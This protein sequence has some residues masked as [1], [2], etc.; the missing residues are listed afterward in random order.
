[1][2]PPS[3]SKPE[4]RF[5]RT[6]W[7]ALAVLS[8][9]VVA[10]WAPCLFG[11]KAPLLGD[12]QANML[13]WRAEA[14]PPSEATWDAL[15]WDGMAQ[16]YPWRAFCARMGRQGLVPLWNPHQFCGYPMIANGQSAV[17]YPPN[18]VLLV[19]ET[20]YAFGVVAALHY[21]LAGV[22][23]FLL[24]REMRLS[25]WAGLVGAIAFSFGGFIVTWTHL[26]TLICTVAWLPAACWAIERLFRRRRVGDALLLAGALGLALL[27]GHLQVA[28]YVWLTAAAH[29]LA[30]AVHALLGRNWRPVA[31]GALAPVLGIAI[32][33]VQL[34]PT[35]ELAGLS[36]RGAVKPDAAGFEFRADRALQP[37]MLST[38]VSPDSLGKPADWAAQGLAYSE[39][40]GYVGKLTLLL[41]LVGLVASRSRRAWLFG[42]VT[43]IALWAAM[44]GL[45]SAILYYYVPG[46]GK[47][48]GF[49][50][51][52]CVYTFGA[53]VL[54]A[55]GVDWLGRF[56]TR[57]APSEGRLR[58]IAPAVMMVVVVLVL[59]D[60]FGWAKGFLPLSQRD[61]V[62]PGSAVA[63]QLAQRSKTGRV[64]AVTPRAA[65]TIGRLPNALLPP[66]AASA[67]GYDSVQG[68]DSL[69]PKVYDRLATAI[70]PDGIAPIANGNMRLLDRLSEEALNEAAVR[71]IVTPGRWELEEERFRL[72]WEGS[73]V[74][75]YENLQAKERQYVSCKS[76]ADRP[77]GASSLG[78]P[79]HLRLDVQQF[80]AD[81]ALVIADTFYPG[82]RAFAG[83][84]ELSP[85]LDRPSF[86]SVELPDDASSVDLVYEPSSF[87]AGMFISLI[88]L[89][90]MAGCVAWGRGHRESR[91]RVE[92]TD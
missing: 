83:L 30:R 18:W 60:V 65:W 5:S 9:C 69:L 82:W 20:R 50:R 10:F 36:P 81:S 42:G 7:L 15:L 39:T 58:R 37:Q 12:A 27:A 33:S 29:A 24:A 48:G 86:R 26:P 68:Y 1:M 53:S 74:R 88:A 85:Q 3:G 91:L 28:A 22:F 32:A 46:I 71:W 72:D 6:D 56:I 59:V 41:A 76:W 63:T 13:P 49:S 77:V 84:Q 64:L 66:N 17:F 8:A 78:D 45:P 51:I 14:S 52:L 31:L 61:R 19:I 89:A 4:H 55:F 75:I 25:A 92:D 23:V 54:A 80:P 21:L 67:Y 79:C 87:K 38:L 62:Y 44:A 47:A 73:G 34:L 40:C 70:S 11:D 57:K 2:L 90:A 16:Y 35:F 43:C